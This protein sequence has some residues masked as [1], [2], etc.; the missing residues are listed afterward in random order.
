MDRHGN[1]RPTRLTKRIVA[2]IVKQYAKKAG[3]DPAWY[4]GHSL[5]SGFA[6]SAA[7]AG[8][9]EAS[10]MKQTRHQSLTVARRYIREGTRWKDHAASGIGL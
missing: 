1:I 8:K 2:N 10:I 6:T 4:G 3:F 9:S 5:R 7:R